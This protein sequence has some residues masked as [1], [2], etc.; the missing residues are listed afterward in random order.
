M[1]REGTGY[2]HPAKWK[3]EAV[4]EVSVRGLAGHCWLCEGPPAKETPPE[5]QRRG[6]WIFPGACEGTLVLVESDVRGHA[7]DL[8]WVTLVPSPHTSLPGREP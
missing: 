5:A 3:R 7:G 8:S 1:T 2:P 4:A 6:K